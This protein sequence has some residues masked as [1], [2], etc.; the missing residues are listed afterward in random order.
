MKSPSKSLF[1]RHPKKTLIATILI[2]FV[3]IDLLAGFI[4]VPKSVLYKCPHHYYHHD[5]LPNQAMN[6]IRGDRKYPVFTNSL[7]LRDFANTQVSLK[8]AR[9]G[10]FSWEILLPK[11]KAWHMKT[12]R[13]FYTHK[14]FTSRWLGATQY[15]YQR[16]KK[17]PAICRAFHDCYALIGYL[18]KSTLFVYTS[19]FVCS[20]YI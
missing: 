8:Q 12:A 16:T 9:K 20:L 17:N 18:A 14:G 10:L 13:M 5:H 3:T 15:H 19:V 7:G 1:Q 2:G 11:A 6:D 4:L